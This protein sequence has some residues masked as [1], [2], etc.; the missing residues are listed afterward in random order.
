MKF[1]LI[2]LL[3]LFGS[4]FAHSQSKRIDSLLLVL[5]QTKNDIDKAKTLNAL[6]DEYKTSDP[7][8]M[9]AYAEK[10]LE[11]SKK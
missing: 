1:K 6:S 11:L 5:H 4:L 8:Q 2:L 9:V 7:K 3:L 10:A